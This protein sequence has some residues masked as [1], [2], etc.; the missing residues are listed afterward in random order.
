MDTARATKDLY[1][2]TI[3]ALHWPQK[4]RERDGGQEYIGEQLKAK[5]K[6]CTMPGIVNH[7]GPGLVAVKEIC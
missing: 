3:T 7:T 5:R 2:T 6:Y 4:S 1:S